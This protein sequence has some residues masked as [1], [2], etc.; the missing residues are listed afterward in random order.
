MVF[1]MQPAHGFLL[2]VPSRGTAAG[3][4]FEIVPYCGHSCGAVPAVGRSRRYR[5]IVDRNN[6]LRRILSHGVK[7]DL[8]AIKLEVQHG[9]NRSMPLIMQAAMAASS[10]SVGLKASGEP[11]N[12]V[13]I[14]T[15]AIVVL[16]RLVPTS[17]LRAAIRYS[18]M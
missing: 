9:R 5:F 10:N 11:A 17:L 6:P 16:A 7:A 4:V 15:L 3:I 2:I 18:S 12:P 8:D 14:L 1:R 13:S